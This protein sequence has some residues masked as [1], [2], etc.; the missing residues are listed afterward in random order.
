M[1]R[2]GSFTVGGNGE[3]LLE[4]SG[5]VKAEARMRWRQA[6][7][8][9]AGLGTAVLGRGGAALGSEQERGERGRGAQPTS[10]GW[11]STCC[12]WICK[13]RIKAIMIINVM[14][15]RLH[16]GLG[17]FFRETKCFTIHQLIH[18]QEQISLPGSIVQ[19]K[20]LRLRESK[21]QVTQ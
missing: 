13:D 20:K 1:C 19:A 8:P 10:G 9:G 7:R 15:T 12:F 21:S 17:R 3:L 16:V 5:L 4:G 6:E 2:P 14:S 18:L 11:V